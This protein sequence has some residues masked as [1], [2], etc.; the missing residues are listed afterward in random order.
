MGKDNE[1]HICASVAEY[2][3]SVT[4][5]SVVYEENPDK[6]AS[7]DGWL[8]FDGARR[9]LIE[10]KARTRMAKPAGYHWVETRKL[11][12]LRQASRMEGLRGLL[13]FGYVDAIEVLRYDPTPEYEAIFSR[14]E[15]RP[16]AERDQAYLV[17]FD[18]WTIIPTQGW[19]HNPHPP[20]SRVEE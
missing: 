8:L 10:A 19:L 7:V 20:T 17:P 4:S 15:V 16:F 12:S 18:L 9:R 1:R 3:A 2:L 6:F 5:R 14:F 11:D 13:C